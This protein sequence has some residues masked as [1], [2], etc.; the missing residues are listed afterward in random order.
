[1]NHSKRRTSLAKLDSSEDAF[2]PPLFKGAMPALA[3]KREPAPPA[4]LEKWAGFGIEGGLL[5]RRVC[6]TRQLQSFTANTR[7]YLGGWLDTIIRIRCVLRVLCIQCQT[8]IGTTKKG[9]YLIIAPT[10]TRLWERVVIPLR[11]LSFP[12]VIYSGHRGSICI[13]LPLRILNIRC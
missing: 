13:P 1:M 10:R 8:K 5:Q 2:S 7:H 4:G 12:I 3:L 9:L 11:S 6:S